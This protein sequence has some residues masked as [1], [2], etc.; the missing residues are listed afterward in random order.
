[1]RQRETTVRSQWNDSTLVHVCISVEI[2]F[3]FF[4][5]ELS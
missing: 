1:M 5:S 3:F 4:N 2:V